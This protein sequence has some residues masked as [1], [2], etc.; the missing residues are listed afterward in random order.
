MKRWSRRGLESEAIRENLLYDGNSEVITIEDLVRFV[1][2]EKATV[3]RNRDLYLIYSRLWSPT[4]KRVEYG[5][6]I[7]AVSAPYI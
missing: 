3:Y 7:Q 4:T 2:M 6:F 5:S 1:N